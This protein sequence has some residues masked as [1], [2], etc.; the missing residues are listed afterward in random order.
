[1]P[2]MVALA[3]VVAEISAFIATD[4]SISTWL[5]LLRYATPPT[6]RFIHYAPSMKEDNKNTGINT[7]RIL[8]K[9]TKY[10]G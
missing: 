9:E 10:F 3:L 7:N 6:A 1:M 2:N 8:I 4:M 5:L